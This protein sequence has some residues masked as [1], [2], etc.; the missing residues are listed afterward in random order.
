MDVI[1]EPD[2]PVVQLSMQCAEL[3]GPEFAANVNAWLIARF[4]FRPPI[5]KTPLILFGTRV[6]MNKQDYSRF[7][8]LCS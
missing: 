1:V 2:V 3:V 5:A 8:R 4:G 7:I 6:V